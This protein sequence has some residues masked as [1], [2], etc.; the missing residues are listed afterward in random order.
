ML[1]LTKT[2]AQGP[3]QEQ[4]HSLVYEG[5][6]HRRHRCTISLAHHRTGTQACSC[7]GRTPSEEDT[8]L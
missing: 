7:P 5:S 4:A 2:A 8:L 6:R 1:P 3:G